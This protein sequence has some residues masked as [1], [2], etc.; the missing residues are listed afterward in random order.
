MKIYPHFSVVGF[1]NTYVVGPDHGGDAL[2]IDPGHVDASLMNLLA[3]C[4]FRPRAVLL[5]H[6]HH[7]HCQGLGTLEKVYDDL[8]VYA[9]S[10]HGLNEEHRCV[11]DGK[12][13]Q[14]AGFEVKAMHI[15]GHS[16]DSMVYV[17]DH[18]I[19]SGDTL[20]AS[21]VAHTAGYLEHE[22]LTASIKKRLL[23]LDDKY[24]LFPGHGTISKIGIER[25]FNEDLNE[26]INLKFWSAG[27]SD[28][29]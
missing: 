11:E 19:F 5:T 4:G 2:I 9:G 28:S 15:P 17:I 13:Y 22:L 20:E 7:A 25:I 14:I 29:L 10:T 8:E 23:E 12:R 3:G 26:M 16:I 18:A 24:L 21:L 27:P 6:C 1:C